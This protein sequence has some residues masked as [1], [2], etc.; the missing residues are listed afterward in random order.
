[1]ALIRRVALEVLGMGLG[2]VVV[3]TDDPAVVSAVGGVC[4]C[5]LT[6]PRH[7]NGTERVAEVASLPEYTRYRYIIN[8]QGDQLGMPPE[9]VLRVAATV[10]AGAQLATAAVPLDQKDQANP[11][12]VKV[13]RTPHGDAEIFYRLLVASP[14]ILGSALEHVGVYAYQRPTLLAVIQL[15]PHPLEE[16]L[17]LEQVRFVLGGYPIRVVVGCEG[18]RVVI[19]TQED[20]ERARMWYDAKVRVY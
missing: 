7:R 2:H 17:G 9:L 14:A 4:G 15:P 13:L 19:D 16:M 18:P 11:A 10:Q 8:Y 1:M 3:A 20:V 5:Q 6:S 12:R